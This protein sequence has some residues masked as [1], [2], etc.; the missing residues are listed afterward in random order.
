[1]KLCTPLVNL[2]ISLL[3]LAAPASVLA[4][5]MDVL[6]SQAEDT[7]RGQ[8][9]YSD[10]RP[11][12]GDYISIENLSDPQLAELSATTDAEGRFAVTGILGHQY[13]ITAHGEEGHTVQTTLTLGEAGA[14]G[15]GSVPFYVIVGI[16]LLLSIIPARYLARRSRAEHQR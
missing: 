6:V 14:V 3:I 5:G 11:G 12:V 4:H 2:A 16:L 8:V 7:I 9:I 1:M 10:G 15:G 13:S